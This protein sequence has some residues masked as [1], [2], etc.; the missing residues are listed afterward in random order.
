M[1]Q[2]P[3]VPAVT[4]NGDPQA[5]RRCMELAIRLNRGPRMVGDEATSSLS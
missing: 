2:Q 5:F 1:V 4:N 3:E